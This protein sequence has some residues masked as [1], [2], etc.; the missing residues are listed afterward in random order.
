V[1]KQPLQRAREEFENGYRKGFNLSN[2]NSALS[3]FNSAYELYSREGDQANA[4][5]A[6]TLATFSKALIEPGRIENWVNASNA[7]K[8]VGI[9]EIE[10]TQPV[11]TETLAQECELKASE[12]K[13]RSM[14]VSA[15]KAEQLEE[16]AKKYL[17]LGTRS[18]LISLLLEKHQTS[19]QI[20]AHRI[21][22]EA[23]KLRGDDILD[24]SPE[25]ASEF[26]RMAAIHMKTAGDLESFQQLSRKADDFSTTA[27]CYFCGR[28]VHGKE[29]NFVPMK[30]HLTK[31]LEKQTENQ[32]LPTILSANSVIA[33]KGCHS[34]ITMAADEI[35]KKYFDFVE[36]ELKEFQRTVDSKMKAVDS[37]MNRLKSRISSLESRTR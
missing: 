21:I 34:A 23:A 19:A 28:E 35:A 8:T 6:W 24:L 30:A 5:V 12:L 36:A 9:A 7:L 18:L 25:N 20:K 13:A 26:Y 37:E 33:C 14:T 2:W 29:V 3:C 4:Q 22:A 31:F 27:R 11:P 1:W 15:Q 32:A 17:S 16:V 10:I